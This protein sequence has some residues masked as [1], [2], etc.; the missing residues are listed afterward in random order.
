VRALCL[1]FL[2]ILLGSCGGG[3]PLRVQTHAASF[4][5]AGVACSLA[6]VPVDRP[7]PGRLVAIGD[8][9]GD[10]GAARRALR[11]AGAIDA[12]DRWIGGAMGVVQLGDILDRGD[13]ESAI[14]D[15]FERLERD[16][17]AAGGS[18]TWLLGNHELMNASGD[19]R[20]VTDGGWRDFSGHREDAL[21]LGGTYRRIFAEQDVTV[22]VGGSLFSHAGIEPGWAD[23]LPAINRDA[24]CWLSGAGARPALASDSS[25][26]VWTRAWGGASV[27]CAALDRVLEATGADRMVV[28][29][30]VQRGGIT[31]A[32]GGKLWRVDTGMSSAYGG[33]V[34]VLEIA[35]ATARAI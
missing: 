4:Q 17:A 32:C 34:Q 16:A 26:P 35:G 29:H 1:P 25:G 20:Y 9:H 24:R 7:A 12:R 22:R 19:F 10:I 14:V 2:A 18:F 33:Q 15:L 27:D 3:E 5:A 28:A 6:A 30:S 11:R 31:S 23:D 21:G 13:G 8:L